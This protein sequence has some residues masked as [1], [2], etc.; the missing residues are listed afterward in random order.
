MRND[1]FW[2]LFNLEKEMFVFSVSHL[3]L[4]SNDFCYGCSESKIIL[5]HT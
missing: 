4:K 5:H 1:N 3:M 2:Q